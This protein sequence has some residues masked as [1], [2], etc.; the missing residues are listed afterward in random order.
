MVPPPA[1]RPPRPPPLP[2]SRELD[3]LPPPLRLPAPRQTPLFAPQAVR[4]QTFLVAVRAYTEVLP[5][6]Q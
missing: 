3:P 2:S 5:K 6:K 4:A 1:V